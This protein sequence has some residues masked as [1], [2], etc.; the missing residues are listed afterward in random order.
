LLA[1]LASSVAKAEPGRIKGCVSHYAKLGREKAVAWQKQYWREVWDSRRHGFVRLAIAPNHNTENF[2]F[3]FGWD[4]LY[5][6]DAI[7][8]GLRASGSTRRVR[9]RI[10][11]P[12][13]AVATGVGLTA[14]EISRTR[15]EIE[16]LEQGSREDLAAAHLHDLLTLGLI[17]ASGLS[18]QRIAHQREIREWWNAETGSR[19]FLAR[20]REFRA[21]GLLKNE[22]EE[23]RLD[24]LAR[25]AFRQALALLQAQPEGTLLEL[26]SEKLAELLGAAPEFQEKSDLELFLLSTVHAPIV[27]L[28]N[29]E[30]DVDSLNRLREPSQVPGGASIAENAMSLSPALVLQLLL[31][32]RDSAALAARRERGQTFLPAE[33]QAILARSDLPGLSTQ[34]RFSD[35]GA[36]HEFRDEFDRWQFILSD[37]R[38]TEI[39]AAWL[40]RRANDVEAL[41]AFQ[42]RV[43]GLEQLYASQARQSS[44]EV[45]TPSSVCRE[46]KDNVL[47]V[48]LRSILGS[49]A[50]TQGWSPR[51]KRACNYGAALH[52][53]ELHRLEAGLSAEARNALS[54]TIRDRLQSFLS[55][56]PRLNPPADSLACE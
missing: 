16:S 48:E 6:L 7:N 25:E 32:S 28:I 39:R 24:A 23:S 1:L 18:N 10:S 29:S 51:A 55:A 49:L 42:G 35:R 15:G 40:E 38:F 30:R 8:A 11:M 52:L 36:I 13:M 3:W 4:H 37:P 43:R 27:T 46:L 33:R 26:A 45:A 9:H 22:W 50:E 54:L 56:C 14:L 41:R 21:Q 20:A 34:M 44:A 2:D 53:W 31:R 47:F 17:S 5:T 19:R 12:A